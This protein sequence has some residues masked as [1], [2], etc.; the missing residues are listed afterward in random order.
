RYGLDDARIRAAATAVLALGLPL[1]EHSDLNPVDAAHAIE[2][3]EWLLAAQQDS[4]FAGH[5]L[6]SNQGVDRR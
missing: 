1:I 5:T 2:K 4:G 6:R 3:I